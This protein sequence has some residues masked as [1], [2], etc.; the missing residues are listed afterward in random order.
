M[1]N[2]FKIPTIIALPLIAVMLGGVS[3]AS[4]LFSSPTQADVSRKPKNI[5]ITNISDTSFTITWITDKP[6]RSVISV[7][8]QNSNPL[9]FFDERAVT[10]N[11]TF[12]TH[13]VTARGLTSQTVYS[14]SII[15][16]ERNGLPTEF[17]VTTFPVIQTTANQLGP[18]YG[19]VR[20]T[21]G[22]PAEGSLVY[23]TL[24]GSQI[25][26]TVVKPSGTFL[27][28]LN[29]ARIESGSE[30]LEVSNTSIPITISVKY[31][32]ATSTIRTTTESDAPV[33]DI[34]IGVNNDFSLTEE[35]LLP[36]PTA[37]VQQPVSFTSVLGEAATESSPQGI[38]ITTPA[39]GAR[40]TSAYPVIAGTGIADNFV[41]ITLGSDTPQVGTTK[42]AQDGTWMFTPKNPVGIGSQSVTIT[43]LNEK[44]EPEVIT[45]VFEILKSGTQVLGD[46]TPS[47]TIRTTLYPTLIPTPTATATSVATFT[48]SPVPEVPTTATTL[49][50]ISL[51]LAGLLVVL[52]GIVSLSI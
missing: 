15:P 43:T 34:I 41:S 30:Y 39:Q 19:T 50:T 2:T 48:P 46:A 52:L 21:D 24:P 32:A 18:T 17:T 4:R 51:L 6:T 40:I 5:V 10:G 7:R 27:I 11:E 13:S 49:P 25:L 3:F 33:P 36:T 12:T 9:S 28:P 14:V 47:A 42:V 45:H 38:R 16:Q 35:T 37:L 44:R 1:K 31:G 23:L 22:T 8:S 26:S 29:L 20:F